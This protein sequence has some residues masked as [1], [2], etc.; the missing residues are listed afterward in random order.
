M[1]LRKKF[2]HSY[3]LINLFLDLFLKPYN[4]ETY[5]VYQ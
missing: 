4:Y 5:I 3:A 2:I 1:N